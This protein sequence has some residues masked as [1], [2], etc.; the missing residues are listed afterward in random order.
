MIAVSIVEKVKLGHETVNYDTE[1]KAYL[2]N[3]K[4]QVIKKGSPGKKAGTLLG[5][6]QFLATESP[7]KMMKN[8]FYFMLKALFVRKIFQFLSSV[9]GYE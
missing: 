9:F 6:R 7:L 2:F 4:L 1:I 5:L 8:A 3:P